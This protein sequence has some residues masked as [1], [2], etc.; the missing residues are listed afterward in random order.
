MADISPN[1]PHQLRIVS[2]N[3]EAL[4]QDA[5]GPEGVQKRANMAK[6][7]EELD[8]DIV[9]NQ[10]APN[11][12][13]YVDF[14]RNDLKGKYPYTHFFKTN[15]PMNHHLAVM[16]KYPITETESHTD[17]QFPV[18]GS[19]QPGSFSRDAGEAEIQVGPYKL[20]L[21]DVHFKANPYF[22]GR[23]A[24]DPRKIEKCENKRVGEAGEVI[25][26]IAGG[27]KSIPSKLYLVA[28]DM[29]ETPQDPAVQTLTHN[30]T[31]PLIDTLADSKDLSHP[32]AGKRFDYIMLSPELSQGMVQGSARVYHSPSASNG[33]DHLPVTLS[34][35]L[36]S[37][38]K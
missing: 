19:D 38:E 36:D 25:N 24:N 18:P 31:A 27:M 33:S 6:T 7:L 22:K 30:A 14:A 23:G 1:L 10:E 9:I 20:K 8:G 17:A 37:L 12:E 15:D 3:L 2:Y 34:I 21:F 32:E 26:L 35:D 28:G 11:Q 5:Q 16:S 29:N 4:G 13:D